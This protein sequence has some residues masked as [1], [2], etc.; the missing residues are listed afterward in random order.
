MRDPMEER[1]RIPSGS[2]VSE[3]LLFQSNRANQ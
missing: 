3:Q 2:K 1:F